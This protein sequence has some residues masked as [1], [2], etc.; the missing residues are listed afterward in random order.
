MR[1]ITQT[2]IISINSIGTLLWNYVKFFKVFFVFYVLPYIAMIATIYFTCKEKVMPIIES[3]TQYIIV[4]KTFPINHALMKEAEQVVTE[5]ILSFLFTPEGIILSLLSLI[6]ILISTTCLYVGL[7]HTFYNKVSIFDI[8]KEGFSRIFDF[9]WTSISLVLILWLC[10]IFLV[11]FFFIAIF[12]GPLGII[13]MIIGYIIFFTSFVF[14]IPIHFFSDNNPFSSLW[15][16]FKTFWSNIFSLIGIGIVFFVVEIIVNCVLMAI[17]MIPLYLYLKGH[18]PNLPQDIFLNKFTT[19]ALLASYLFIPYT[20][21]W[22]WLS[23]LITFV[24]Y[25]ELLSDDEENGN[26]SISLNSNGGTEF[27]AGNNN[28]NP[29]EQNVPGSSNYE[30]ASGITPAYGGNG[31]SNPV[32]SHKNNRPFLNEKLGE[33]QFE[34]L[35]SSVMKDSPKPENPGNVDNTQDSGNT[36]A[37]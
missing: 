24:A 29:F 4:S 11:I 32:S 1:A 6:V 5:R 33:T 26:L 23:V 10:G 21:G 31:L 34:R 30:N 15:Y 37:E 20:M 12:L 28:Q 22:H 3:I 19:L 17:T 7:K 27:V 36:K 16:S 35:T 9:L 25:P 14:Y 13:P 8:A 18:Y 2:G